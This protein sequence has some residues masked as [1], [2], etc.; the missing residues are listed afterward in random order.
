MGTAYTPG[1]TV[2]GRACVRKVRRLPLKG[3]VL[4]AE[5]D[6]VRP[7]TAIAKTELPGDITLLRAGDRL[8]VT[9]AELL[10]LL[11]VGI[12]DA[13]EEG[14]LLAE[15]KG[16]F[17]RFF[18]SRLEAPVNGTIE[19]VTERTGNLAIR[20]PPRPVVL[21]AYLSGRVAEV[22]PGDGAVIETYGAFVQGIFGI[23]GERFG[24]L[25]VI[26][27]P[28]LDQLGDLSGSILVVRGRASAELYQAAGAAGAVG[29]VAGSVLDADLRLILDREIGVAI[30]GEEE[31]AASLVVTEGFGEVPMAARTFALLQSLAGREASLCGATQIRAGVIR[32]EIIVPD[33]SL[34]A[35]QVEA[36][37]AAAQ[38]AL[39]A[40][41]R[42]RLIREPY[43]GDLGTVELLPAELV[44]I[45]SGAMTRVLRAK[46][47][48]GRQVT[49]PRA[50]VEIVVE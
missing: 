44:E 36:V 5:G 45:G 47:D 13:I 29:V 46:L 32:P 24:P 49:V 16:L 50:N 6:E 11:R 23:G 22:M 7:D 26:E 20:R 2:S 17:G 43:F 27:S 18:K 33:L 14:Q 38:Q 3:E 39:E 15:T 21:N 40:G 4:V 35:E 41:T 34:T 25:R 9:G 37:E 30:T 10:E 48:D 19:T 12:G 8:G 31:V 28:D 1:L 42:V